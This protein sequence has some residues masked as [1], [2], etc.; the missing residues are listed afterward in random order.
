MMVNV[1]LAVRSEKVGERVEGQ[2]VLSKM[3]QK[4][5]LRGVGAA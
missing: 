4:G 3:K 5:E 1:V 2:K